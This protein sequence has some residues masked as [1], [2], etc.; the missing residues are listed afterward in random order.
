[1]SGFLSKLLKVLRWIPAVFIGCCSWY[2]S[3]QPHVPM[4]DFHFSDKVVHLVCFAGFSFFTA[5]AF[6]GLKKPENKKSEC[7]KRILLPAITISL[8]GIIDEIHQSFVPGRSCS[9]LDWCADTL[10]ALLGSI[11]FY[12][13][14]GIIS[15]KKMGS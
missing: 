1:M 14:I 7:P 10:G 6:F 4:P 5:F 13:L 11:V 9:F 2:L 12:A 3:S 15:R 8:Y